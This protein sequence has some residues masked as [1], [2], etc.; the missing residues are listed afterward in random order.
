MLSGSGG[1]GG[2]G[3]GWSKP[4]ALVC[5]IC[6]REYGTSSLKI[7]LPQCE[8]MWVEREKLKPRAERRPVPK[9]ATN[10]AIPTGAKLD[11]RNP[12]AMAAYNEAATKQF[13]ER[14]LVPCPNCGRTF[15]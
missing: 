1:I 7:H 5:H 3:S 2:G 9:A 4:A 13:N 8:K 14:A 6:G 15:L 10:M 12:D 11:L